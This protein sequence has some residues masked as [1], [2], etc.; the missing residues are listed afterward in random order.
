MPET[1]PNKDC[2]DCAGEGSR[3]YM[4]DGS[5]AAYYYVGECETCRGTGVVETDD[6]EEV[7]A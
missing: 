2:P 4:S 6:C 7:E 5:P 3:E 1:I